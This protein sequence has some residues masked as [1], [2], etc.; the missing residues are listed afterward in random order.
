MKAPSMAHVA[1]AIHS[2]EPK[3]GQRATADLDALSLAARAPIGRPFPLTTC[4]SSPTMTHQFKYSI[5]LTAL[6]PELNK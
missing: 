4:Y 2:F 6:H 3:T 1:N 5:H